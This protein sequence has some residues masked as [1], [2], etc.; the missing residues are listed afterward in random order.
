[1]LE[2]LPLLK[3]TRKEK[4][5]KIGLCI[6]N[7]SRKQKFSS[8]P[9]SPGGNFSGS[10]QIFMLYHSPQRLIKMSCSCTCKVL[11]V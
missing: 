10:A 7:P 11:I 6:P 4:I 8:P 5:T 9:P 1:M 2:H 3:Q